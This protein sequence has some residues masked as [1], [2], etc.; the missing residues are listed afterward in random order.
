MSEAKRKIVLKKLAAHKT[1]WHPESTLVFK[2]Q[3]ERLVIG[4]LE[5]GELIALDDQCV[6]LAEEWSFNIDET[7]IQEESDGDNQEESDREENAEESDREEDAEES[8]GTGESE[9]AEE[10]PLDKKPSEKDQQESGDEQKQPGGASEEESIPLTR[11]NTSTVNVIP[12]KSISP[13]DA[14]GAISR[15]TDGFQ[16]SLMAL[17]SEMSDGVTAHTN[18]LVGQLSAR[19][20]ELAS[21]LQDNQMLRD[22]LAE[23]QKKYD[24]INSK[25]EAMK[26]LFN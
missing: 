13:V 22:Q 3:K 11:T 10:L 7:L 12:E 25:F 9:E 17:V 16:E 15:I 21:A 5:E 18:Q 20:D 14:T 23:S 1:I 24:A 4:R 26:S 8:E 2:S 19:D 6:S